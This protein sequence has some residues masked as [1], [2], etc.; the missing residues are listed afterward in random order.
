[1]FNPSSDNLLLNSLP[2]QIVLQRQ[3]GNFVLM[4][5]MQAQVVEF[6]L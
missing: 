1:M 3:R 5:M 6:A 2:L 4:M